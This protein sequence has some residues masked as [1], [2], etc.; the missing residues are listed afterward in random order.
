MAPLIQSAATTDIHSVGSQNKK[1]IPEL[2]SVPYKQQIYQ[3]GRGFRPRSAPRRAYEIDWIVAPVLILSPIVAIVGAYYTPL[4]P[5]T[6]CLAVLWAIC[7]GLSITGGYHRLWSHRAYDAALPLQVF[8]AIFG[9]AAME[10]SIKWWCRNHRA[11][12]KFTDTTKDPYD[13][14]KSFFWAHIGWMLVKQQKEE[15]GSADVSDLQKSKIVQIQHKLYPLGVVVFGILAPTLI[16]GYGWGDFQGGFIYGAVCKLVYVHHST[17]FVNSLAHYLGEQPYSDFH[18]ACDSFVTALLSL[19]EGYH[20]YHH[21]FPQDY[22]NGI[23][24][25]QFDPTKWFIT[26]CYYLGMAYNLRHITDNEIEKSRIQMSEGK[27]LKER[28]MSRFGFYLDENLPS[29]T[30]QSIDALVESGRHV[31]IICGKVYDISDFLDV[32]PGGRKILSK[33]NGKDVS[34]LFRGELGGH[35]HSKDAVDYLKRYIIGQ[36]V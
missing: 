31:V 17:F 7:C 27:A 13:V 12:H 28:N 20:N 8:Y 36:F 9:A 26:V 11:H 10:G 18:T 23:R 5:K 19:G 16:A 30:Q 33:H 15:V 25:Y 4:V 32:H 14:R 6:F 1:V 2:S 24:W 22:R 29:Y 34:S 35:I 3:Q 21:E